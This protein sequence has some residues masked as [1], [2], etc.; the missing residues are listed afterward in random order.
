MAA[1]QGGGGLAN[2]ML[3]KKLFPFRNHLSGEAYDLP[4]LPVLPL[5]APLNS[6]DCD[7]VRKKIIDVNEETLSEPIGRNRNDQRQSVY[8]KMLRAIACATVLDSQQIPF[9]LQYA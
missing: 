7:S 5:N 9:P 2:P 4:R 1:G 8:P 6:L 3:D